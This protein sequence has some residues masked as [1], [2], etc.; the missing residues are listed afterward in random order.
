M[1]ARRST[2]ATISRRFCFSSTPTCRCAA[3][4][5]ARRDGSST[6]TAAII[7][8][9]CRLFESLM[10]CSKSE[11]TRLMTPSAS[12]AVSAFFGIIFTVTR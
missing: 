11:T 1:R 4:V 8:S 2:G 6:R 10:Y 5:S 9:Y 12:P 3:I 7:A